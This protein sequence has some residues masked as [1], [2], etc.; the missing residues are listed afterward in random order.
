MKLPWKKNYR[1]IPEELL[2][3]IEGFSDGSLVVSAAKRILKSDIKEGYYTHLGITSDNNSLKFEPSIIPDPKVGRYSNYNAMGRTIIRRDLPMKSKTY[4]HDAPNF[5][6]WSKGTH[7]VSWSRA[8]YQRTFW[9]PRDIAILIEMIQ[10]DSETIVIKFTLDIVLAKNGENFS[11]ELLFQ[12]NLLQENCGVCDIYLLDTKDSIYINTLHVNWELLPPGTDNLDKNTKYILSK[13]RN[14]TSNTEQEIN[15]RLAFFN[16]LNP[17]Q[18]ISG[19]SRFSQ[20]FGAML[21]EDL[22]LLE[23]TRY[24]NAIYIFYENWRELSKLSR[25][26]ILSSTNTK[27]ERVLHKGEWKKRVVKALADSATTA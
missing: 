8:V 21:T 27:F 14:P 1:K 2:S 9:F 4:S 6:D 24:G 25:S 12:C 16:E 23:N 20:Y 19:E 7:E 15:D 18:Y 3:K 22:V 17:I 5:G 11:E 10:E 13:F 26:E